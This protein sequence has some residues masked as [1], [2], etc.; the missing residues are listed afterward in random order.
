MS[1]CRL[2]SLRNSTASTFVFII[3]V[4]QKALGLGWVGEGGERGYLFIQTGAG[5][6]L[7]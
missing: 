5:V 2:G 1:D 6:W 3:Q 7:L 4:A